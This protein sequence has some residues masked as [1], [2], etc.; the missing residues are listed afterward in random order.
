MAKVA[1]H[2]LGCKVNQ[3]ETEGMMTQFEQFGY[4]IV[5]FFEKADIY[6]INT[7]TVTNMADKK[8][9]QMLAKAKKNNP[10]SLVVAVGC[11]VQ[12]ANKEL[13]EMIQV[14]LLI[15]NT[16]KGNMV[17]VIE[18]YLESKIKPEV[19][20]LSQYKVYDDL[21]I[22]MT[23]DH[24]RAHIKIQDGCDQF[25][26][27]CIIPYARGRIRSRSASSILE[28][29]QD[30]AKKGY[31]EVVLTGIHLA[32]YGI[33][34]D[35]YRLIDLLE[36]MQKIE[37]I[38]RIRLGSLEPTLI[39][40]DFVSRIAKL[41]KVCPHFHLSLQSGDDGVLKKM[42]RKY[43]TQDYKQA[44]NRL[45]EK[46]PT[47]A[48]TTDLIVGFPSETE[49]QFEDTLAF[50]KDI[51]FA[52]VHVFKYSKR[53]GTPAAK[54]KE[55]VSPKE[56]NNRSIKAIKAAEGM[57]DDF[58]GQFIGIK[59]NVLIEEQVVLD[60]QVYYVGHTTNHIKVY[61]LSIQPLERNT[62]KSIDLK[63]RFRDGLLGLT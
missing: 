18:T 40:K 7:C 41:D 50:I 24:T 58:L 20:D 30:L 28:E 17:Q 35:D 26:T 11:Y 59:M 9:R 42:N 6:I 38:L 54:M 56:K 1:F 48:I 21:W 34:F 46:M 16:D 10:K 39:T 12:A 3:Y 61:T 23:Q 51:G 57:K 60:N 53:S 43:S 36:D 45:R 2:T 47:C 52:E 8:S 37:G 4:D 55:Q 32:S 31:K 49:A 33:Q 14:D 29:S 19:L 62:I 22:S 63:Q 13:L 5:G 44:V 15:G 25:C 27:Y